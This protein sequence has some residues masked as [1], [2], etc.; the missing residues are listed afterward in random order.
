MSNSVS[1]EITSLADA[2]LQPRNATHRQYEALRAYFVEGL[3][4]TEAARRFGYTP[5]SFRV[6]CHQFR[7]DPQREFFRT[8]SKGPA[9]APKRDRQRER[10]VELRKHNLSVYDIS[11]AL[12]QDGE[13]LS[14]AAV[15]IL[16]VVSQIIPPPVSKIIPRPQGKK[17]PHWF[18]GE[19]ILKGG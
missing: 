4:S 12:A 5:A 9:V 11:E 19:V 6:L 14:P 10:V 2:F 8:P 15:S 16:L 13:A 7:Q 17:F 1:K 3:P 18:P